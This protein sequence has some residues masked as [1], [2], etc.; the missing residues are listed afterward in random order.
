[1]SCYRFWPERHPDKDEQSFSGINYLGL[2]NPV[3]A[4]DVVDPDGNSLSDS[5]RIRKGGRLPL[6]GDHR[7]LHAGEP[8]RGRRSEAAGSITATAAPMTRTASR[9]WSIVSRTS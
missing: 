7:R 3:I 5:P 8:R 2:P 6:A 4:A 9:S 1:M